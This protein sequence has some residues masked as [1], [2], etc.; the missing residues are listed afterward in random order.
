MG[1]NVSFMRFHTLHFIAYYAAE[2][3]SLNTSIKYGY[4]KATVGVSFS[5]AAHKLYTF[6]AKRCEHMHVYNPVLHC[7][8][9]DM[10]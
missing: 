1:T 8:C 4:L 2:T 9:S 5:L 3:I 7:K 6:I 10:Y